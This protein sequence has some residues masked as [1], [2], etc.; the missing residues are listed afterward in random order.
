MNIIH[1]HCSKINT[2]S[3]TTLR[4]STQL[5]PSIGNYQCYFLV[6]PSSVSFLKYR[7]I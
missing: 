2:L 4:L 3:N 6:T 5:P 1:Y 7:Q